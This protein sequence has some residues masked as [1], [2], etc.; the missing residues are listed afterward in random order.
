MPQEIYVCQT[1]D[2]D[3]EDVIRFDHND[4]TYCVYHTTEGFLQPMVSALTRNSIWKTAS[5]LIT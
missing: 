3:E 5:S 2:I 1:D 4:Q